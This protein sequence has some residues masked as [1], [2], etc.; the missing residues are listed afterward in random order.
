VP[1]SIRLD[2]DAC[3]HSGVCGGT[4]PD[5]FLVTNSRS[6]ALRDTTEPDD[7]L[8]DVAFICPAQAIVITGDQGQQLAP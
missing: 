6:R 2:S 5:T 3:L 1:W 8:L 7:E 4:R